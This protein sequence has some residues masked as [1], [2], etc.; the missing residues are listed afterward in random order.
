MKNK[1][2]HEILKQIYYGEFY[3]DEEIKPRNPDYNIKVKRLSNEVQHIFKLLTGDNEKMKFEI[4][5]EL[6][7]ELHNMEKYESFA[8]GFS[9]GLQLGKETNGIM[10]E[11]HSQ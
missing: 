3:P 8:Y 5:M 7:T 2:Y 10:A 6:M 4:I 9:A 11:F 1:M